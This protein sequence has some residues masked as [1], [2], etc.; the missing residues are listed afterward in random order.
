MRYKKGTSGKITYPVDQEMIN[1]LIDSPINAVSVISGTSSRLSIDM[2]DI[3][4]PSHIDD[5][6]SNLWDELV[7]VSKLVFMAKNDIKIGNT[8]DVIQRDTIKNI[9][10]DPNLEK[11]FCSRT[12]REYYGVDTYRKGAM[13]VRNDYPLHILASLAEFLLKRGAKFRDILPGVGFQ[14]F[15]DSMVLSSHAIGWAIHTVSPNAFACKW[16][17]GR[18]R[19]EEVIHGWLNG[20]FPNID[21]NI[22]KQL[23]MFINNK[24]DIK[25]DQNKFT[26]YS[27][28]CPNHPS[29]PA[30]HGAAAGAGLL[31]P[32]LF[33]LTPEEE[34]EVR[35][36]VLNIAMF[37]NVA[38][39]HYESDSLMGIQIGEMVLA[40]KLPEF[41]E[42][43]GA[44]K[45]DIEQLILDKRRTWI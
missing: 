39:V 11:P 30:M 28:G 44:I 25:N 8:G 40:E 10:N 1:G 24:D 2:N 14:R 15:T 36:T 17:H 6:D 41:L 12:I 16:K 13:L 20:D 33:D 35:R 5:T 21:P 43:Y 9:F 29:Y 18:V 38:G 19:P 26:L 32:I 22:E 31:F 45:S 42:G 34:E 27:E 37:R 4:E 3:I 7:D 23:N